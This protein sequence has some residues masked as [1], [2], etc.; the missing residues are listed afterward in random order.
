VGLEEVDMNVLYVK[1]KKWWLLSIAT[2]LALLF[3][4]AGLDSLWR[5][6][7]YLLSN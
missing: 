1:V 3:L 7:S 5:Q 6:L 2:C 4:Y